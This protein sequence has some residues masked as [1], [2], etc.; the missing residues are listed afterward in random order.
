MRVMG[1]D[2]G[3]NR[4][5][6]GIVESVGGALKLVHCGT[7]RTPAKSGFPEKLKTIYENLV[8]TIRQLQ[9]DELAVE[10]LF[11]SV[12]AKSAL[13]LGQARGVVL[14]AGANENIPIAEYSPLEV[15]QS[16]VGYGRADKNQVQAMVCRLL[17]M[18]TAPDSLDASDALAIAICHLHSSS[19]RERIRA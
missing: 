5:G 19:M 2:P 18:K 10:D 15:K 14:L 13:K 12:N 17:K 4:T 7:I 16:T 11:F 6:Y 8:T 3:S 9:P 1:I